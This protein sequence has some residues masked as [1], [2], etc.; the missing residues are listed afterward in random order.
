MNTFGL[1]CGLKKIA[2]DGVT[3]LCSNVELAMKN[4]DGSSTYIDVTDLF[5][6]L[7]SLSHLLE[8]MD[9]LQTVRFICEKGTASGLS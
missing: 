5:S 2:T 7:Q 3:K 6:E 1:F 9:A 8:T 4:Y